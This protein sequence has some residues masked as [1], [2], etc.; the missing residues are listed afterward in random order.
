MLRSRIQTLLF[1]TPPYLWCHILSDLV[2]AK[3]Q[4]T[5]T[6]VTINIS[7]MVIQT[8]LVTLSVMMMTISKF[9]VIVL[10]LLDFACSKSI[11]K[12]Q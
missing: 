6:E 4:L 5:K 11:F 7:M 3:S 10:L 9:A 2:S 8:L 12:A 1:I